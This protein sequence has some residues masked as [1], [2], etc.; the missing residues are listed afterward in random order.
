[1]FFEGRA[2][3]LKRLVRV[4]DADG[5]GRIDF[6]EFVRAVGRLCLSSFNEVVLLDRAERSRTTTQSVHPNRV[7]R[8]RLFSIRNRPKERSPSRRR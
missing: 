6:S 7:P 3:L 5:D 8:R 1:M 2:K 4:F